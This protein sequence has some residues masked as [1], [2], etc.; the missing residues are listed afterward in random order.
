V[1]RIEAGAVHV[2]DHHAKSLNTAAHD[3]DNVSLVC[4]ATLEIEVVVWQSW[5][6][7]CYSGANLSIK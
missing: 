1:V 3:D 2:E 6:T 7:T 4:V 5:E